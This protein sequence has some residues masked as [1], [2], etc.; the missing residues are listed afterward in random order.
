[1]LIYTLISVVMTWPLGG[2]LFSRYLM[3]SGIDEYQFVWSFWWTRYALLERH[4]WPLFSDMLYHPFGTSLAF[5]TN[6]S[7]LALLGIP[8]TTVWGAESA[9]NLAVF[10]SFIF[11]AFTM[12][13]LVNYLVRDRR[14]A[15]LGGVI[16]AFS[17]FK[18]WQA[19]GH[20]DNISTQFFPLYVLFFIKMLREPASQLR[21][22]GF[23]GLTLGFIFLT[24]YYQ[25][26]YALFFSLCYLV[27]YLLGHDGGQAED[28]APARRRIS[29][30]AAWITL[31]KRLITL[32]VVF[33]VIASPLLAADIIDIRN[34][35]YVKAGGED[36]FYA[37]MAGFFV[38]ASKLFTAI[39][40]LNEANRP[41]IH[42]GGIESLVYAG[43]VVIVL[44]AV[45]TMRLARRLA[46]FRFWLAFLLL[47]FLFALG[48]QPHLLGKALPI[49]GPYL[50]WESVP[51]L[52]NACI[53]ARFDLLITFAAGVL[54]GYTVRAILGWLPQRWPQ[55]RPATLAALFL[56]LITPL[57]L[58]EHLTLPFIAKGYNL[59]HPII[60]DQI[61]ATPG[62]FAVLTLPTYSNG[63]I[64]AEPLAMYDQ[65]MHQK[66]IL[67][68]YIS[69]PLPDFATY[70]QDERFISALSA[71]PQGR[72][73]A[74]LDLQ[75]TLSDSRALNF[76]RLDAA[77]LVYYLD[78]GYIVAHPPAMPVGA[79]SFLSE[80]L[81]LE[82]VYS[83]AA[84]ADKAS[85]VVYR[86]RGEEVR[87][88]AEF[89]DLEL[90]ARASRIFRLRGW[91]EQ[92]VE[93]KAGG[94]SYVRMSSSEGE[95]VAP[96]RA[97]GD[98]TVTATLRPTGGQQTL[99]IY[100]NDE[101]SPA[102][103]VPLT[104]D[105]WQKQSVTIG[106]AHWRA[107]MNKLRLQV[108][109]GAGTAVRGIVFTKRNL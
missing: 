84:D 40:W 34:G 41:I 97:A 72:E 50:L 88:L 20:L 60:F 37:D 93:D 89:S 91:E 87:P 68:A 9:Y 56:I 6:A 86:V 49:P 77:R 82:Q 71:L 53:P 54:V 28:V 98:Y 33:V 85:T 61:A 19:T 2:N 10:A 62:D 58:I 102:T 38:P 70:Y 78:I 32:T 29:N 7:L 90:A 75:A 27:Y 99:S 108:S 8:I 44:V 101:D 95:I 4:T 69:R 81:P 18:F 59:T 73:Q 12:Y 30:R 46:E 23:A 76:Y 36:I 35:Y 51:L 94:F 13:L 55:V 15:F 67:A 5:N 109:G 104:S 48:P 103:S 3:F 1:L 24:D 65:T 22:A 39:P 64:I 45:G 66:K 106:S 96:V 47:C 100:L 25:T 21:Y 11:S 16:F 74:G 52:N 43:W 107:G 57:M 83:T 31:V 26:V 63:N 105:G 80:T 14:A 17:T 79:L 92:P 42:G